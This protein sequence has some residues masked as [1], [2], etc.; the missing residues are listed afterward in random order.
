MRWTTETNFEKHQSKV[1]FFHNAFSRDIDGAYIQKWF[2]SLL[3]FLLIYR[4]AYLRKGGNPH[5]SM[6]VIT[7]A[8][9]ISTFKPYLRKQDGVTCARLKNDCLVE[10]LAKLRELAVCYLDMWILLGI[11]HSLRSPGGTTFMELPTSLHLHKP[12]GSPGSSKYTRIQFS[13]KVSQSR[14]PDDGREGCAFLVLQ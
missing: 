5:N 14:I 4:D 10:W 13:I 8:A 6:Y 7:P 12:Q 2:G 1:H 11:L 9:Q 3:F